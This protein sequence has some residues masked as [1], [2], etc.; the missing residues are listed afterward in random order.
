[1]N[2]YA[3]A[4]PR[5]PPIPLAGPGIGQE[6]K[7]IFQQMKKDLHDGTGIRSLPGDL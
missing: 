3:V 6:M 5:Y 4:F 7:S 1:M 2:D